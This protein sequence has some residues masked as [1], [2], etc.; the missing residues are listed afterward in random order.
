MQRLDLC[1]K[2]RMVGNGYDC[3]DVIPGSVYSFLLNNG[4]MEDPHYRTNELQATEL[5]EYDYTF[6]RSFEFFKSQEDY[7]VILH[8]DGLDTLSKICINGKEVARTNNMHR[9]YEFEVQDLLIDGENSIE[10]T[11]FSPNKYIKEQERLYP[12]GVNLPDLNALIGYPHLRKA[13][14]MFGW[15]WGAR[16]PDAGIWRSIYLLVEDS[17][18]IN[19]LRITQRHEEGEV[20]VTAVAEIKGNAEI[21]ISLIGPDGEKQLLKNGEEQKVENPKIW[22]PNGMGEHPLYTVEVT[23]IENGNAVDTMSKRIGLRE[24]KLIRKNDKYG[25]SFYHEVN[26]VAIFAKGANYIPEDNVFSRITRKRTERLLKSC[27]ECNFNILRVWGGG[28]YCHDWFYDLCDEMGILI[29]QDLMFACS[30]YRFDDE[31]KANVSEEVRQNLTRIRHHACIAM[32]C[33]NNEIEMQYGNYHDVNYKIMYLEMFEDI[34]PQIVEKVCAEIPY[35]FSSPTTCGHFVD[36]CNP[37]CGTT[38]YWDT[39]FCDR[40]FTDYRY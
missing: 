26:G 40:P 13:S 15:D 39:W 34:I 30:V 4:L 28:Y 33:G 23:L 6:S 20:F 24:I 14:C 12:I 21:N 5:L 38:H 25:Q 37:N 16:L 18:R 35:V 32:I 3:E 11:F 36:P 8:C 29:S 1:G 10:I 22:W 19:D 7:R 9:M 2:W 17:S 31:M 27:V